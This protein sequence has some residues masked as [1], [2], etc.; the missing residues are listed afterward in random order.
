LSA[1][2]AA[3]AADAPASSTPA[4]AG[5]PDASDAPV[6]AD[7]GCSCSRGRRVAPGCT[8]PLVRG[9]GVAWCRA[10]GPRALR[11]AA[12]ARG[13]VART[14]GSSAGPYLPTAVP[15]CPGPDPSGARWPLPRRRR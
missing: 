13:P 1:F 2:A 3:Q 7:L 12:R 6:P 9:F 5:R 4:V 8:L 15:L 10:P 14:V 11:P